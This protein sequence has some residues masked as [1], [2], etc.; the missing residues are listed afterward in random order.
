MPITSG[1]NPRTDLFAIS[2]RNRR[3][4]GR[5]GRLVRRRGDRGSHLVRRGRHGLFF[6]FFAP[7]REAE[8][9]QSSKHVT[10]HF[11]FLLFVL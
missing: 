2:R 1:E 3:L 4:F 5:R 8:Q 7:D 6:S 11:L 9:H 10:V